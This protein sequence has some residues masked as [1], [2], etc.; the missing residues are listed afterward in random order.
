MICIVQVRG[1]TVQLDLRKVILVSVCARRMLC[2][3]DAMNF[4][5]FR[6]KFVDFQHHSART[7]FSLCSS[8][9]PKRFLYSHPLSNI[10]LDMIICSNKTRQHLD[11]LGN[12]V[13]RDDHNTICGIAKY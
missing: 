7:L 1:W 11:Y 13:P 9:F 4:R 2:T 5:I 10:F 3:I 8:M 12:F 6:D